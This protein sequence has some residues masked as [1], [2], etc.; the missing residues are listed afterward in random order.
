MLGNSGKDGIGV[1]GVV[2]MNGK[3]KGRRRGN[4]IENENETCPPK[5]DRK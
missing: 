4:E 2:T 3:R 5:E 1:F